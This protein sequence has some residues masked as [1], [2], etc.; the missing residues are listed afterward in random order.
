MKRGAPGRRVTL[1]SE[2]GPITKA[3]RSDD[4]PATDWERPTYRVGIPLRPWSGADGD[5]ANQFDVVLRIYHA[6][7]AVA[8][9]DGGAA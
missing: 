2:G 9:A 3:I 7:H 1:S 5:A 8:A 6:I 4:S